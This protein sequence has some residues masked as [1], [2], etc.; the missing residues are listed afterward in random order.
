MSKGRCKHCK[1]IVTDKLLCPLSDTSTAECV[2]GPIKEA[3]EEKA[4]EGALKF[5]CQYHTIHS[6]VLKVVLRFV[7]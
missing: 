7:L 3:K 4:P 5:N 6:T 1:R 2:L